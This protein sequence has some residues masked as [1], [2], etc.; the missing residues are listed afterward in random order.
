MRHQDVT[1]VDQHHRVLHHLHLLH[2]P[3]T[4][5]LHL[6][7]LKLTKHAV[8][9]H[10]FDLSGWVKQLAILTNERRGFVTNDQSQVKVG[11]FGWKS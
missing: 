3:W 10:L 7:R 6:L 1:M 11:I 2:V 5:P 9:L 4:S 8:S